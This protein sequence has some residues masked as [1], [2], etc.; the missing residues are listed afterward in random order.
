MI[1]DLKY[2]LIYIAF[3]LF[4]FSNELIP[5]QKSHKIVYLSNRDGNYQVFIM[6][7]DGNNPQRIT[8]SADR[9]YTPRVS[10]DGKKIIFSTEG[11]I[12]TV[13][14]IDGNNEK[15]ISQSDEKCWNPSW[16]QNNN[17]ILFAST[18]GGYTDESGEPVQ[19]IWAMNIDGTNP[20]QLTFSNYN[21]KNPILSPDGKKIVFISSRDKIYFDMMDNTYIAY[22]YQIYIMNSDGSDQ[23]RLTALNPGLNNYS[24]VFT[25]DG[26]KIIYSTEFAM[27][28]DDNEWSH[29]YIMNSD[30]SF[31][32]RLSPLDANHTYPSIAPDGK[33]ILFDADIEGNSPIMQMNI[34]GSN[35][36][37]LSK[38]SYS[39]YF[40]SYF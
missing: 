9:K 31:P 8:K 22:R 39:N 15:I 33:K 4:F 16:S 28:K 3:F 11:G 25:P 26:K 6:D 35:V 2:M 18:R 23:Q 38:D 13:C 30:G 17:T 29:I 32:T 27:S 5:Q 10:P 7:E 34:D 1:R 21:N 12:L 37:R 20:R 24:P 40:A 36:I 19:N 14:D